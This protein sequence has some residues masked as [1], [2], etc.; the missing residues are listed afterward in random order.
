MKEPPRLLDDPGVSDAVKQHLVRARAVEIP[1]DVGAAL[2][3]VHAKAAKVA[4][5]K[6]AAVV[7]GTLV[8]AAIAL[9]LSLSRAR[10]PASL[11]AVTI[12]IPSASASA[13]SPSMAPPVDTTAA[14][15]PASLP[16]VKAVPSASAPTPVDDPDL[17][18]AEAEHLAM[19]RRVS[20]T[21][22]A[23]A[24]KLADE[25]NARFEKGGALRPEREAIAVL[26]LAKIGRT[27]EA[28]SRGAAFLAAYPKGP[29]ADQ[30]REA[31]E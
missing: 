18:R 16:V 6:V 12:S 23:A 31:I 4:A 30:V 9:S 1:L 26:S 11:P 17:L 14:I 5:F 19:L 28:K 27:S 2:Q 10:S 20:K 15:D 22:P 24:A 21:D 25:G 8:I 7:V 29:L 13:P 3:G